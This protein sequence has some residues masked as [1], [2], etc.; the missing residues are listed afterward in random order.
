METVLTVLTILTILT[1]LPILTILTILKRRILK[2]LTLLFCE[3]F[4]L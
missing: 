3:I 4:R 1:I 2:Y